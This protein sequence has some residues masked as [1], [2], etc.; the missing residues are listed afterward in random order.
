MAILSHACRRC[1]HPSWWRDNAAKC[2]RLCGCDHDTSR[3]EVDPTPEVLETWTY[4]GRQLEPLYEPGTQWNAGTN[5]RVFL[6]N[7]DACREQYEYETRQ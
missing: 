7:C 3:M 6:C 4:P 2:S 1:G 5:H